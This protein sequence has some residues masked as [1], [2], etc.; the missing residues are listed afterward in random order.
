MLFCV[1]CVQ[2]HVDEFFLTERHSGHRFG[3]FQCRTGEEVVISGKRFRLS[4]PS[5]TNQHAAL[6]QEM[7]GVILPTVDFRQAN[8]HDVVE[9]LAI[10]GNVSLVLSLAEGTTSTV[11]LDPFADQD[12]PFGTE[13]VDAGLPLVTFEAKDVS[14]Y[15]TLNIVC[16]LANLSWS[17]ENSVVMIRGPEGTQEQVYPEKW[18]YDGSFHDLIDV[19]NRI[20]IRNGGFNCCGP[21]DDDKVLLSITNTQEIAEFKSLLQ[22]ETNQTWN[23]CMC[24]GFPGIDWYR[25]RYRLALTGLQHGHALRWK[26][27][28]GDAFFTKKSSRRLAQWLLD[29]GI[30]DPHK[31]FKKIT[32]KGELPTPI[33]SP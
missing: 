5:I 15:D 28:P 32:T 2:P 25:G 11:A 26:G 13:E 27:F 19:A 3:P 21:V 8:I 18:E 24:C 17:V 31:E 9:F 14:V 29:H 1:G 7:K 12:D 10:S 4:T 6:I 33:E 23:A 16:E 22:F 20:V 30:P